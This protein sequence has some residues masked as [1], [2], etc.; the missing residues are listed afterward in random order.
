M[1]SEV[2]SGKATNLCAAAVLVNGKAENQACKQGTSVARQH[3]WGRAQGTM[4]LLEY[5]LLVAKKQVQSAYDTC[6]KA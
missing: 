4:G 6:D 1:S 5:K 2:S 3:D